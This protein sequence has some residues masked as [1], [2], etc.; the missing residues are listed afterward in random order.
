[1]Y[2]LYSGP[3]VYDDKPIV[4]IATTNSKN[5]KTGTMYQTWIMRQ[6]I[7]PHDAVKTN[8][9][10]SVC[11]M[12]PLRPLSYKAVGLSRGCY[13]KTFQAPLSVWK[14]YHRG[15]YKHIP[16]EQFRAILTADQKGIR[17]GS[18]GDP[19]SVPLSIWKSIGV[20]S[21]EFNH[22]GYTHAYLTPGFDKRYL[23]FLMLS[24]DP[25]TESV[26]AQ[27]QNA[28]TFRVIKTV[29]QVRPGEIICPASEEAGKLTNCQKCGLCAGLMS[30]A[31]NIA[32]VIH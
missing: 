6:D 10:S 16:L 4:V 27:F 15:N 9:D 13:V 1:M 26:P 12:C 32:I 7:A 3:S 19:A 24:L 31:K 11:G 25:V 23:D 21:N 14:S 5:P 17:L 22:T 30:K 29:D 2:I 28:R 20:G 8:D 18:Y